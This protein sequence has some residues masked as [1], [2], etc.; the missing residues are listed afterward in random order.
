MAKTIPA[1]EKIRR[2]VHGD[3]RPGFY[4]DADFV[5]VEKSGQLSGD[6]YASFIEERP[7]S[8]D[9]LEYSRRVVTAASAFLWDRLVLS[10]QIGK[11]IPVSSLLSR[12]L[13]QYE[14]WSYVVVGGLV[15]S[16]DGVAQRV[17][18]PEQAG[19]NSLFGHA[20][21]RVPPFHV[22]DLTLPSQ[23]YDPA[24]KGVLTRPVASETTR[25]ATLPTEFV[26]YGHSKIETFCPML[27]VNHQTTTLTYVPYGTALPS[28][29]I[30]SMPQPVLGGL[31]SIQLFQSFQRGHPA[32]LFRKEPATTNEP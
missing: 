31:N 8:I 16:V 7:H 9:Y 14:V 24:L 17:F 18:H 5:V 6:D 11:C 19:S 32:V 21:L 28:E 10:G 4:D 25:R 20:W 13:E 1:E 3:L 30:E 26:D 27:T 2:F 22:V 23:E 29:R 12:F 15:V